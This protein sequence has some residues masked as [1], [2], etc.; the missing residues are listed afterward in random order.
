MADQ[1]VQI[2][3]DSVG[4]ALLQEEKQRPE[5]KRHGGKNRRVRGV[6]EGA[7]STAQLQSSSDQH[8]SKVTEIPGASLGV[9]WM[10]KSE[11]R[12]S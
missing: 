8:P 3:E 7:F 1:G 4:T 6:R 5:S 9:G 10:G 12:L 11:S 2:Q